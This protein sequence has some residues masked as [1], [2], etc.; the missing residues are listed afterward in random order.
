MEQHEREYFIARLRTGIINIKLD[1][2]TLK[3][4]PITLEQEL[5]IQER[6]VEAYRE[7]Q[8]EGFL[9][10]KELLD[11]LKERDLWTEEDEKKEEGLEKDID[12]LKVELFQNKNK[13]DMVAQIRKYLKAGKEQLNK[14]LEKKFQHY[15]IS[16]E[17]M[18]SIEKVKKLVSISC[19][20][21]KDNGEL[22]LYDFEEISIDIV[23]K[24]FGLQMLT[25]TSL[26]ELARSEPWRSTWLL[27]DS[28]AYNLFDNK[29]KQL[30]P[31]QRGL[32]TFSRMYDNVQESMDC[33]SDDVIEDDDMLDGWFI[34]Q[35]RQRDN[36][37]AK[38]EIEQQTGN[39]KIS[40]SD[41]IFV[42]AH[43]KQ[44]A[45]KINSSNSFHA[46][47]VKEQRMRTIQQQGQAVDLDFQD[48]KMKYAQMSNEK[49]KGK[50]RR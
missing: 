46:Q 12:R 40:N 31:D 4:K 29:D 24:L 30:T 36:D 28:N 15:E 13:S 8:E 47:K 17:G 1:G 20:K 23:I 42:M 43:S 22:E 37:R 6:Y 44:D 34:L 19:F 7:A 25:E 14:V 10:K 27:R 39:S 32:L 49:F 38:S 35:K 11:S 41:E 18:A 5:E 21:Q 9:T 33:P 50:F 45:S 2:L 26:R 3:I 48:Q 16:C